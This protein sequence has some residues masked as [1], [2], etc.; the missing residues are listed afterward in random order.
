MKIVKMLLFI[1]GHQET[2]VPPFRVLIRK[3]RESQIK[4]PS[5]GNQNCLRS[6]TRP[7]A[8][9]VNLQMTMLFGKY[10]KLSQYRSTIKTL[11]AEKQGFS[12]AFSHSGRPSQKTKNV[13]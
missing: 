7:I 3:K 5:C 13:A 1:K 12:C 8:G 6:S 10:G 4:L 9:I 11:K 2:D